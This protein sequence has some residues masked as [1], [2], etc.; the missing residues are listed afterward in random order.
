MTNILMYFKTHAPQIFIS[1]VVLIV[2][3]IFFTHTHTHTQEH[4]RMHTLLS[5]PSQNEIQN[6]C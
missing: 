2:R 5:L 3:D 4:T 1:C 6:T